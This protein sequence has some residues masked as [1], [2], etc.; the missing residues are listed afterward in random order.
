MT[1]RAKASFDDFT[2]RAAWMRRLVLILLVIGLLWLGM[3]S[4]RMGVEASPLMQGTPL[5]NIVISEFRTNGT[6]GEFIEIFNAGAVSVNIGG[7]QIKGSN[8]NVPPDIVTQFTIPASIILMPGQ[9][10]VIAISGFTGSITPDATYSVDISDD[11]GIALVLPPPGAGTPTIIVDAVGMS[12]GSEF[13]EGVPLPTVDSFGVGSYE[14]L[15]G[16]AA[17]S[18]QDTNNNA[19][20]FVLINPADPQNLTSIPVYC[21]PTATPTNTLAPTPYPNMSVIINEVAWAGTGTGA[22]GNDEWIELYNPGP[23]EIDFSEGTG[24]YLISSDNNSPYI[25]LT[26][27]IPSLGYYLLE[28]DDDLTISDIPADQI[29]TGDLSNAGETL[30]LWSPSGNIV[31]KANSDPVIA[32]NGG[33]T[34]PTYGSMERRLGFTDGPISWITN[35]GLVRN[36]TNASGGS[37]NGTPK[38]ENWGKTISPTP[39]S[40]P[41][42]TRTP[43]RVSSPT[44]TRTPTLIRDFVILNEVLPHALTDL[45]GDGK[46]DVG[47]EY[48]ELINL[49]NITVSLQ[50]WV[51]D[52]RD[53]STRGYALPPVLMSPGQKLAFFA[54]QTGQ[55]LSDGGDSVVLVRP[56]GAV[57]DFLTYPVLDQLGLAWCRIPDGVGT[58]YFGCIPTPNQANVYQPNPLPTAT[59]FP[60]VG[61][62]PSYFDACPLP[63]VD[64]TIELAECILPGLEI[65]NPAYWDAPDFNSLPMYLESEKF[66]PVSLE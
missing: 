62:P 10:Y 17:G 20:D 3:L 47:D 49:S 35:I 29:Y 33:S 26:G 24:W 1:G 5:P 21:V 4:S 45:N 46:V 8:S 14:R 57:A 9:H 53:P 42:R 6:D 16:G 12:L 55:Y 61:G 7:W 64:E 44:I 39:S 41:T 32:W 37:I 54:S 51:L 31:D 48:I 18:C 28:R 15:N 11:G 50:R 56:G 40:T 23:K 65:W 30:Y 19:G 59:P 34:G 22:L 2:T 66:P 43:T 25:R 36:G 38:E 27:K 60:D 63:G 13:K 52:D 58:W